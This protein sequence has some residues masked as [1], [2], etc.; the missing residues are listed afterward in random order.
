MD[1]LIIYHNLIAHFFRGDG[2]LS[3]AAGGPGITKV[4]FHMGKLQQ[5]EAES[6]TQ[7]LAAVKANLGGEA[8]SPRSPASWSRVKVKGRPSSFTWNQFSGLDQFKNSL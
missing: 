8:L 2:I 3:H 5:R 1:Y 4:V 6:F 7:T